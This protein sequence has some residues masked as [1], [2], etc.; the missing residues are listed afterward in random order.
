MIQVFKPNSN[1]RGIEK[2]DTS[3]GYLG[4]DETKGRLVNLLVMVQSPRITLIGN[5]PTEW[6]SESPVSPSPT[7]ILRP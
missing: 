2:R 4:Y 1:K 5:M 3:L 6:G 7:R